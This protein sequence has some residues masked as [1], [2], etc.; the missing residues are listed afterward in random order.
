MARHPR[1]RGD[2]G[3]NGEV[4]D[5]GAHRRARLSATLRS[6]FGLAARLVAAATVGIPPL[7]AAPRHAARPAAAPS[8]PPTTATASPPPAVSGAAAAA[9]RPCA[10][11]PPPGSAVVTGEPSCGVYATS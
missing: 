4:R 9:P 10:A 11:V 1:P 5:S 8:E 2:P 6:R 7:I 3:V